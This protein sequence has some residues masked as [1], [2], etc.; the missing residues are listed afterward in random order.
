MAVRRTALKPLQFEKVVSHATAVVPL[1]KFSAAGQARR[2]R[3]AVPGAAPPVP[4]LQNVNPDVAVI[5]FIMADP[6]F[7]APRTVSGK[8]VVPPPP[9]PDASTWFNGDLASPKA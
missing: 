8:V 6:L 4:A 3:W 2:Q 5:D 1:E 7:R 9:R